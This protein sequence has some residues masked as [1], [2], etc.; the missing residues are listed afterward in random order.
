MTGL[1]EDDLSRL[2]A[3]LML[4]RNMT[5]SVTAALEDEARI[6]AALSDESDTRMLL[7]VATADIAKLRGMLGAAN[8]SFTVLLANRQ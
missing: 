6:I 3:G 2:I 4:T 5:Q 7:D 8:A 1:T